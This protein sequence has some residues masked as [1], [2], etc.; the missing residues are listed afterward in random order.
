MVDFFRCP[1]CGLRRPVNRWNP[2]LLADMIILQEVHGAGRGHGFATVGEFD[3]TQDWAFRLDLLAMA[4]RCLR[5]VEICMRSPL[6][7]ASDLVDNVPSV[8]QEEVVREKAEEYG[9]EE[10]DT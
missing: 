8:L 3:A 6:V 7:S 1:L 2:E 5:I 4:R 10:T 9:Y